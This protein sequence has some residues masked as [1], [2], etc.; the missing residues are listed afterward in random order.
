MK[1]ETIGIEPTTY[2]LCKRVPPALEHAPPYFE[3]NVGIKPR[4]HIGSVV[5]Y[6]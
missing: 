4:P 2:T 1:V 6:H 3:Q 5:L